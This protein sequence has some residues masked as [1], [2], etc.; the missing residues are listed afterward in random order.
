MDG[1]K[2]QNWEILRTKNFGIWG[3]SHSQILHTIKELY[4]FSEETI[5]E[6]GPQGVKEFKILNQIL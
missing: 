6:G 3:D 5:R 2:Q 1:Y 4:N